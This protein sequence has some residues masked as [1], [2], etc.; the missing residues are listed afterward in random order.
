MAIDLNV[1]MGSI[2]Q[3]LMKKKGGGTAGGSSDLSAKILPFRNALIFLGVTAILFASYLKLYYLPAYSPEW[4]ADEKV[5]NHLKSS[6][7]VAHQEKNV[8]G[9]LALTR[10]KLQKMARQPKLLKGIFL[11]CEIASFFI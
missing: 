5:W 1:D 3:N 7:L 9:L 11:R 4:N 8:E 6:E 2:I 10:K